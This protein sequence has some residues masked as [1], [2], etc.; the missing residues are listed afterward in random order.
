MH[1]ACD[2]HIVG[3]FEGNFVLSDSILLVFIPSVHLLSLWCSITLIL[4]ICLPLCS[5]IHLSLADSVKLYNAS[6]PDN[7]FP[8]EVPS[9]T[10]RVPKNVSEAFKLSPAFVDEWGPAID[11]ENASFQKYNC[12]QPVPSSSLRPESWPAHFA[13][14]LDFYA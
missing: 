11:R 3:T 5:A 7:V 6:M 14:A 13:W 8:Q 9:R 10:S 12:F 2:L 4:I 1:A